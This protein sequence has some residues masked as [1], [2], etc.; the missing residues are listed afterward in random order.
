MYKIKMK[1]FLVS[2]KMSIIA[3]IYLLLENDFVYNINVV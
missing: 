1:N 3:S 2:K